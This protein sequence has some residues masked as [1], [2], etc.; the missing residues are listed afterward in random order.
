MSFF[1]FSLLSS[2]ISILFWW[3]RCKYDTKYKSRAVGLLGGFASTDLSPQRIARRGF[4]MSYDLSEWRLEPVS[5]LIRFRAK[6]W[7]PSLRLAKACSNAFVLLGVAAV[8][9]WFEVK[10]TLKSLPPSRHPQGLTQSYSSSVSCT[11]CVLL[12]A[13]ISYEFRS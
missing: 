7:S 13:L 2:L 5:L 9:V 6:E 8:N 10:F 11:L 4:L 1:R 3:N 12:F